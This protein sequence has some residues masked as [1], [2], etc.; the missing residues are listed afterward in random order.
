MTNQGQKQGQGGASGSFFFF[1]QDKQYIIKTIGESE[2]T[3][4]L[5]KLKPLCM[6]L[7]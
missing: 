6:H 4:L 3:A 7:D 5:T 2:K 1:T